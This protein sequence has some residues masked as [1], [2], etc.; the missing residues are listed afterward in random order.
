MPVDFSQAPPSYWL[1]KYRGPADRIITESVS[2]NAAWNRLAELTDTFGHR[3]SGSS[4]LEEALKW[5]AETMKQDGLEHVRLEPVMVP[6][7]VRGKEHAEIVHPVRRELVMLGLGG[8]IGTGP[9]GLEAAVL[10][11]R[12]L[13]ELD[14]KAEA[15]RGKIV[16]LNAPF[17]HYP[18]TIH[19]R[20]TGPSRAARHGAV[21]LLVRSV[22]PPGYRTAHTGATNYARDAPRIPAAAITSEDADQLQRMFDRGLP[23]RIRLYME[24]ETLPDAPSSNVVAELRG[25]V[26]PEQIVVLG[27][28]LDSW[29]VGTGASDDGG[30]RSRCGKP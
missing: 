13:Q 20:T 6:H 27:A 26:N 17:T 2:N 24:A 12:T 4:S 11:V 3:L 18:E 22:A 23:L 9:N 28:H 16:V 30:G 14:A 7:W 15:A 21:A 8:S 29:D 19:N 25:S 1:D 5:S 10:V